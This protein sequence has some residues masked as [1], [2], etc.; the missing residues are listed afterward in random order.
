M[1]W[2]GQG[3][4]QAWHMYTCA[5]TAPCSVLLSLHTSKP[6]LLPQF[7]FCCAVVDEALRL[8]PPGYMTAREVPP[9][10]PLA[11]GGHLVPPGTSVFVASYAIQRDPALWP[12][13]DEF[14]PERWLPVRDPVALL[15]S[16]VCCCLS[17]VVVLVVVVVVVVVVIVVT[18]PLPPQP[19]GGEALAPV[20]PAAYL[21]FGSGGRQ[22]IGQRFALQEVRLG[23]LTLVRAF[24]AELQWHLM[25]PPAPRPPLDKKRGGTAMRTAV[26]N[27]K[28]E[29]DGAQLLRRSSVRTDARFTLNAADGIWVKLIPRC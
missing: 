13:A 12:R 5:R 14:V 21:P 4:G 6:L 25:P 11:L 18:A 29:D 2:Q 19:Q 7:P 26:H 27:G 10:P 17:V 24:H 3:Q 15:L 8:Y 22:C 1:V 23:L 16:V 20:S 28:N 9:G